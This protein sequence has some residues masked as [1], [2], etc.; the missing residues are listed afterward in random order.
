M[1]VSSYLK[2]SF[3]V[4]FPHRKKSPNEFHASYLVR[5][6]KQPIKLSAKC[7]VIL[8]FFIH[9]Q[10]KNISLQRINAIESYRNAEIVSK[11]VFGKRAEHC[12]IVTGEIKAPSCNLLNISLPFGVKA[13]FFSSSVLC[14]K[15]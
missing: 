4:N 2:L 15:A 3:R 14:S 8:C 5:L 6:T 9:R 13:F 11:F 1:K 7:M 10:H 12:S